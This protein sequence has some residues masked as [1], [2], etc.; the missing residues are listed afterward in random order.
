VND[1]SDYQTL[2][3]SY[4]DFLFSEIGEQENGM[5]ISMVSALTRLGLDPWEE[6]RRLAA[7]PAE[8][9]IT[10]VT[11]LIG[12]VPELPYIASKSPELA[13]RLVPLL[14]RGGPKQSERRPVGPLAWWQILLT[15]DRRWLIAAVAAGAFIA[16][17]RMLSS[18]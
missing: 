13:A 16:A 17:S 11:A 2:D 9:A 10:A 4:E 18:G 1:V 5:P 12:R 15:V 3:S 6:A 8:S 14:A 7:L